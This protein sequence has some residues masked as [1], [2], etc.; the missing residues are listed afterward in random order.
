MIPFLPTAAAVLIAF[1][2]LVWLVTAGSLAAFGRQAKS[3]LEMIDDGDWEY[4]LRCS[5]QLLEADPQSVDGLYL[6]VVARTGTGDEHLLRATERLRDRLSAGDIDVERRWAYANTLANG[7][8][9][10]GSYREA[11]AVEAMWGD[12]FLSESREL[13]SG[14]FCLVQ[15]NLAEAEYNLGK[16]AEARER[17]EVIEDLEMEVV[18]AAG[19]LLQLAWI[20]A[21]DGDYSLAK[22]FAFEVSEDEMPGVYQSEV[23]FAKAVALFGLKEFDEAERSVRRGLELAKRR[24]SERNALFLLGR[25]FERRGDVDLAEQILRVGAEHAYRGQGGDGLLLWGDVL[26]SLRRQDEARAAWSLAVERDAQSESA[27]IART[28][29]LDC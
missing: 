20:S 23:H 9:T 18:P 24:S 4:G 10:A 27:E 25:V 1:L 16:W 26:A 13:M 19:V 17:I 21:H 11:L 2:I 5:R 7:F 29:L 6:E 14:N 22:E 12:A 28:R 3:S 8:I 15:V